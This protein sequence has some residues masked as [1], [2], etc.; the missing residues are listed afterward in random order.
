VEWR[1]GWERRED[2]KWKEVEEEREDE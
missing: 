2:E 1:G